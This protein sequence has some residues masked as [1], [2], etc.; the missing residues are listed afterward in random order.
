LVL[1]VVGMTLGMWKSFICETIPNGF[2]N[3]FKKSIITL[4]YVFKNLT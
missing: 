1:L 4:D 3:N 2:F